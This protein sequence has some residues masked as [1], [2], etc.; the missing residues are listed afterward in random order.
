MD[1]KLAFELPFSDISQSVIQGKNEISLEFHQ[2][3]TAQ[4]EDENLVEMRF[5]VPPSHKLE[6]ISSVRDTQEDDTETNNSNSADN[7]A[8]ESIHNEILNRAELGESADESIASFGDIMFVTPRG[9]FDI[10]IF[11]TFFKLHGKSYSYKILYKSV[12]RLFQLPKS[13]GQSAFIV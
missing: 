2:D 5:F 8:I 13:Q 7:A 12:N 3:D 4:P 9:R 10:E 1:D 6:G 11:P